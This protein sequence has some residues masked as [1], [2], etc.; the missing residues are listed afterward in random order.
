M[1]VVLCVAV[2]VIGAGMAHAQC[3]EGS[4]FNVGLQ[5]C[6][7]APGC[8]PGFDLHPEN[9]V[10]IK[11]AADGKCPAGSSQNKN[12]KTCESPIV[13]PPEAAEFNQDIGKCVGK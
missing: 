2:L 12:E 6:E 5:K 7:M 10:C 9:D 1:K 4:V 8:K 13:C 3:P 11:A